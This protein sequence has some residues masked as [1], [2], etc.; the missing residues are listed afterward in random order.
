MNVHVSYKTPKTP[1]LEKEINQHVEKL[2]RRL[3]VFRPELIHLHAGIAQ[4]SAREGLSVSLNLRLPSGQMQASGVGT[5]GV[6]ALKSAFDDLIEQVTKHKDL[7][8]NQHKWAHPRRVGRTRPRPQGPFAE[9]LAAVKLPTVS[10][11]DISSYV[12]ANLYRL[13]R[14]VDRE[15]RFRANN[16]QLRPGQVTREEVIDETIAT[17]LGDGVEKPER[18]ALEPWLYRLAMRAID[19]LAL[20]NSEHDASVPL[21][22]SHRRQNV[23]G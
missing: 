9:T 6:A 19:E 14:F 22:K 12:N 5:T 18:L 13:I 23:T 7:L 1:D 4:N 10:P 3:Q 8:R 16:G 21:D 20:R 2:R 11:D 15:L 17:A